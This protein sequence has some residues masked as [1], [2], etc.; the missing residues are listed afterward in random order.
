MRN[1]IIVVIILAFLLNA[2]RESKNDYINIFSNSILYS[3]TV[4]QLTEVITH[5]IFTPPVASRIYAYA[6]LAACEVVAKGAKGYR[7]LSGQLKD[8]DEIPSP[9]K[10]DF[11]LELSSLL[12]F[13][14][15]INKCNTAKT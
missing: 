14:S 11:N 3:Q 6:N 12:A 7:T 1:A 8:F 4:N 15:S 9:T 2:C 5:D 13:V 10:T